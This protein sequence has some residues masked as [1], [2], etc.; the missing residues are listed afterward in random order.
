VVSGSAEKIRALEEF[1]LYVG[2]GNFGQI[3]G[4]IGR[5]ACSMHTEAQEKIT[6]VR[7][8]HSPP[9]IYGCVVTNANNA[10]LITLAISRFII[11]LASALSPLPDAT[12][13]LPF[14]SLVCQEVLVRF[15]A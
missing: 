11:S 10:Q 12:L 5:Q 15:V 6:T 8:K 1:T 13:Y 2:A 4:T 9:F 7:D 14:G 3:R